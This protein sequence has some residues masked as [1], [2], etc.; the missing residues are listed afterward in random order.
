[1]LI[2]FFITEDI[3]LKWGTVWFLRLQIHLLWLMVGNLI[4]TSQV[5]NY[6]YL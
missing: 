2:T 1:M 3:Y 6:S 5:G 4:V